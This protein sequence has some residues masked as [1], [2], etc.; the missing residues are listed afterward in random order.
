MIP[1]W[2]ISTV[3]LLQRLGIAVTVQLFNSEDEEFQFRVDRGAAARDSYTIAGFLWNSLCHGI[4]SCEWP[5]DDIDARIGGKERRNEWHVYL[6]AFPV[7]YNNDSVL[8]VQ[9]FWCLF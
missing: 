1:P 6:L 2:A 9:S 4:T 3:Q 7:I 8:I 5:E